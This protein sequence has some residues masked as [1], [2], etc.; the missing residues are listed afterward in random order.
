MADYISC[1]EVL[2]RT[3]MRVPDARST[4]EG[5]DLALRVVGH[6]TEGELS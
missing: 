6:A 5:Y 4:W 1:V 3:D 2:G